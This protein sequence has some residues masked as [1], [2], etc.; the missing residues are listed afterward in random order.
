MLAVNLKIALIVMEIK[1]RGTCHFLS[2]QIQQQQQQTFVGI[3]LFDFV[4]TVRR[5]SDDDN[6]DGLQ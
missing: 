5:Q 3:L 2:P 4:V 1:I 6:D